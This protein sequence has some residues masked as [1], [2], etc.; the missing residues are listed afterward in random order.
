ML[1]GLI[2]IN[3]LGNLIMHNVLYDLIMLKM[4]DGSS[5]VVVLDGLDCK[6]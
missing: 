1:D 5:F 2:V 6:N 4:W 3:L